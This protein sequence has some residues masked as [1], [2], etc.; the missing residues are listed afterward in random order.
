[1]PHT[2][3]TPKAK[4]KKSIVTVQIQTTKENAATKW[5]TDGVLSLCSR[6]MTQKTYVMTTLFVEMLNIK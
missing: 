3:E 1:M 5:F 2:Y 6:V 4:G